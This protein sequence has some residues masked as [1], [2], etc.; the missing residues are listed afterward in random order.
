MIVVL[1]LLQALLECRY[2]V[3]GE[4]PA[5]VACGHYLFGGI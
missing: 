1:G 5:A 2:N 4:A 3:F